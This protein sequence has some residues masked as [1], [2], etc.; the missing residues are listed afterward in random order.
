M[1]VKALEN[2]LETYKNTYEHEL[3]SLYKQIYSKSTTLPNTFDM[4]ITYRFF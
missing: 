2:S 4:I 3:W 1:K